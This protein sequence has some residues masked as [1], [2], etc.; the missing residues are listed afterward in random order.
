MSIKQISVDENSATFLVKI[1]FGKSM[2]DSEEKIQNILNEL[3]TLVTG[4]LLNTF[5]TD[6]SPVIMGATKMTSKGLVPKIYQTPYGAVEIERHVYQS[7]KGGKTFCPLEQNAR[8]VVTS[9]PRFAKQ[10][11]HKFANNASVQTQKDFEINH[12]RKVARSYLQ[13]VAEAVGTVAIAKE[14][15]WKY[16]PKDLG[17]PVKTVSLGLDG[18]CMLL[19]KDGYREAMVGT[20]SLY[21]RKGNRQHTTYVAA[22]P[23]YG[24][25]TFLKKLE[26]L[27]KLASERYP[28]AKFIGIADG[29]KENWNFL[30][31]H[32]ETQ[33]IDFWHATEYLSLAAE[34]I[35]P[36]NKKEREEWFTEKRH[37]LKHKYYTAAKVINELESYC[38]THKL[39]KLARGKAKKVLTY[40]KNNK[41]MMNYPERLKNNEP[42]GSG[43]TE[44]ACKVIVKQ[45]MCLSGAKWKNKGAG[46]VLSLR[47]MV[48]SD[49]YWEQFWKKINQYGFPIAA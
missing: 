38:K 20:M 16:E 33:T 41:H 27:A 22:P 12:N 46:I 17:K 1:D 18:T 25:E 13:N 26:N 37:N 42:I 23:E 29:A 7:P 8:I 4:E 28:K 6:G 40:Y 9:T 24:K 32:T 34:V 49:G 2:L 39:S 35:H 45:R 14:E 15:D 48:R 30:N 44:A 21:D 47:C 11:S 36:K 19:C 43:V 5:D 31:K 10:I 3:G